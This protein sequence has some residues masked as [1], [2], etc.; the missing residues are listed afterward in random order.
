MTKWALAT[1]GVLVTLGLAA[2]I[3]QTVSRE[4]WE[5]KVWSCYDALG[6][7]ARPLKRRLLLP[8]VCKA[9][10]VLVSDLGAP[11]AQLVLGFQ[12]PRTMWL[13]YALRTAD[14]DSYAIEISTHAGI[15]RAQIHHGSD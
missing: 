11:N 15:T 1:V 13:S 7:G 6:S 9:T 3:V 12:P 8:P 14:Y 4:V 5:R 2:M 10:G